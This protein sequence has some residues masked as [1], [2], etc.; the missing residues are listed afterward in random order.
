MGTGVIFAEERQRQ[1]LDLLKVRDKLLVSELCERF[2]ASPATIRDDLN[3]LEKEGLLQRTHGGA[4]SCRKAGFELTDSQKI[5]ANLPQK[6]RI[7]RHAASLIE[8]G[9]TVALDTGTTTLR[10]AEQVIDKTDRTVI[11]TDIRIASVLEKLPG[12]SVILVGGMLRKGFSCTVGAMVNN[13]LA[14][15][16]V[17]KAFLAANGVTSSGAV[18]TPDIEQ[19]QVK[20]SM[21]K[22]G[23]QTFLLCDSS[24][25][26]TQSF[27]QFGRLDQFDMVITDDG[28]NET[29]LES[30]RAQG[31]NLVTV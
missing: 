5:G 23:T 18:C 29:V 13:T 3:L 1:I 26:G 27:A 21:L 17:D 28:L 20:R 12:I 8:N 6:Q 14:G 2:S 10:L 15:L 11:T 24:K 19:A 25:F 22:T 30:L 9:D 31:A 7:A 16:R 4:I